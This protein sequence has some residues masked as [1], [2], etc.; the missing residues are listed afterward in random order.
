[1]NPQYISRNDIDP[2]E[3]AKMREITVD[4]ALNDPFSLPKPI[5]NGLI[6]KAVAGVWSESEVAIYNEKK[7]NMNYLPN[8]LSAESKAQLAALA[9]AD[10][11]AIS[12]NKIFNGLVEGR[13]SKQLKEI[14]LMDQAYVKA[15]DGK[16]TVAAYLKSVDKNLA[17]TK[18]VR[19]EVGEG[20]QK[21]VENFAEEV[22]A[23][24][25]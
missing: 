19:Y 16:Q 3:I 10:K 25:K 13:V 9:M 6:A 14:C 5:L 18:F 17:I 8:F 12:A 1:M 4:A 24:M 11:E 2:A 15:E 7:S 22:A 21:K 23:Q 20:M